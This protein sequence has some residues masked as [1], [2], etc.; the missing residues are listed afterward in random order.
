VTQHGEEAYAHG[1]G[2]VLISPEA[3][4]EFERPVAQP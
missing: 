1:E 2:M 3:G 4:L